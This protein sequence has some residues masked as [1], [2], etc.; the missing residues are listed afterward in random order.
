MRV[1]RSARTI[2]ED[3]RLP[4][5][6]TGDEPVATVERLGRTAWLGG[7]RSYRRARDADDLIMNVES[8]RTRPP[9]MA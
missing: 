7:S 6:E 5:R 1:R 9:A 2:D 3:A 4:L 8:I